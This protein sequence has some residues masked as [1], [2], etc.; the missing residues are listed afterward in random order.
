MED[1]AVFLAAGSIG[2][3]LK[4]ILNSKKNNI[5]CGGGGNIIDLTELKPSGKSEP[6]E[7]KTIYAKIEKGEFSPVFENPLKAKRLSPTSGVHISVPGLMPASNDT[8]ED[9]S[10]KIY[11]MPNDKKPHLHGDAPHHQAMFEIDEVYQMNEDKYFPTENKQIARYR[12]TQEIKDFNAGKNNTAV[13]VW[14]H[15]RI[16]YDK[17]EYPELI[18]R[19]NSIIWWDFTN[20]HNLFIVDNVDNYNNNNFGNSKEISR[21]KELNTLVTFMN[22]KG[23]FYFACTKPNHAKWGHKIKITVI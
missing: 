20:H 15:W 13:E 14:I 21:N 11:Y 1:L 16:P 2:L 7:G 9:G 5:M 17:K 6:L 3:F 10:N 22:K 23:T 18:V 19:K 8:W 4:N 12:N